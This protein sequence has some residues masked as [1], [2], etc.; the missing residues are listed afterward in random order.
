MTGNVLLTFKVVVITPHLMGV[1]TA[2]FFYNF[3]NGNCRL[4]IIL[5]VG[6]EVGG[7]FFHINLNHSGL[8]KH[9]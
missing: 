5:L 2:F 4:L 1:H 6:K 3:L 8:L 9:V 7:D